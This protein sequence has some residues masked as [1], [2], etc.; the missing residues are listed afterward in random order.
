MVKEAEF[1]LINPQISLD[2][3]ITRD[4]NLIQL[5]NIYIFFH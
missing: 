2:L 3:N 4:S 5:K 1:K